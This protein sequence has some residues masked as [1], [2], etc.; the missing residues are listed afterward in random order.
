MD[1]SKYFEN[2]QVQV[3]K[4]Q[5]VADTQIAKPMKFKEY[6]ELNHKNY[7]WNRFRDYNW[8]SFNNSIEYYFWKSSGWGKKEVTQESLGKALAQWD[9]ALETWKTDNKETFE[10]NKTVAEHNQ[11][12]YE[13]I[14]TIMDTIGVPKVFSRSFYKTSRSRK[15][16][17]ERKSAQW[18]SE[19]RDVLP[20]NCGYER[21]LKQIQDKRDSI[22]RFGE[23][24]I[25]DNSDRLRKEAEEKRAKEKEQRKLKV[26]AGLCVK[27]SLDLESEPCDILDSILD[28]DK[29]LH[30]AHY[31]LMNRNDWNDGY[32]YAES[33]LNGF[34]VESDKDQDIEDCIQSCIDT[35]ENGDIDGRIFR[36]C[37]FSYDVL[38]SMS[39]EKVL[40]DY[41]LIN[42]FIE[43]Y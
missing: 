4:L 11:L 43:Q 30:L 40:E 38:F 18:P 36:D 19:I 24:W 15:M 29:Y 32:S 22:E 23:K 35:Q 10:Y 25:K 6:T 41:N 5:K 1:L 26:L 9:S 39:D 3:D 34:T 31:L 17:T 14:S 16:T 8:G 20:S 2:I 13:R 33:G 27:Y 7:H 28:Q 42:E 21:I 37:K 12:Q